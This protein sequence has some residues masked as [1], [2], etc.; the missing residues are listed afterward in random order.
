MKRKPKNVKTSELTSTAP[1]LA[2]QPS[3]GALLPN[4]SG[5]AISQQC[6]SLPFCFSPSPT[7]TA[8]ISTADIST[9]FVLVTREQCKI[10][11]NVHLYL[12]SPKR[13]SHLQTA[14]CPNFVATLYYEGTTATHSVPRSPICLLAIFTFREE[15]PRYIRWSC[16]LFSA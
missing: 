11:S 7:S 4:I 14:L 15:P 5:T 12:G 10:L 1:L 2:R 16:S 9:M 6:P 3:T 8:T 13:S